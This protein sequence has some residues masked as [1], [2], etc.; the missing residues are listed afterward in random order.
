M[1]SR[2]VR[3][4]SVG[5]MI[6]AGVGLFGGLVLW[7]K[8][9]NPANRS[10]TVVAEF[11]TINGV[12]VG[13]PVR[14]RGVNVG[15][16]SNIAAGANGVEVKLE[17]APADL[18]IPRDSTLSVNQTGLLGETVL[19]ISPLKDLVATA[20]PGKPLD[21]D[22][23][24]DLIL[25]ENSRIQ[26]VMGISTDELI[27]AT[28]KF[29]DV[30][31]NPQFTGNINALT[32]N[33]SVAAAEIAQLSREVTGLV[34][35]ARQE[36]GTFSA[37]ARSISNTADRATLTITQINDLIAAN[38]STLVST[39]DN[40][41]AT[42]SELRTSVVRLSPILNRVES[43][44]LINNLE[45][46]SANAV[47]TSANLR[48]ISV[49]LNNPANITMLQQT[50]DSARATFENTQKITSDLDELT[51]DPQLRDNLKRLINGLSGLVSSTQ[52]LQQQAD[53]A[54]ILA[55][56]KPIAYPTPTP[57]P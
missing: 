56:P 15:R 3:E 13:S 25:C 40:L 47:Q 38:R 23:N 37:T 19:D 26:G 36:V 14:Y 48:D 28:I 12:Q 6:L 43:S 52:Q 39:L 33:S 9:L 32:K 7:L 55:A 21:R 27:R 34:K 24:R 1:R 11:E 45:T 42:S 20:E 53:I 35:S 8:G 51:G 5:L 16:I 49:T 2:T 29:A 46:L 22:C 54:Q 10:F 50:L 17:I 57:S 31:S 18:V 4:G 44:Q 30:Y 41:S